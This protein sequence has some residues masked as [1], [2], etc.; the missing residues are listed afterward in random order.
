MRDN[1]IYHAANICSLK[2][3]SSI[4]D[5]CS[6]QTPK[7]INKVYGLNCQ[8]YKRKCKFYVSK[9]LLSSYY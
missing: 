6:F 5:N 2:N 9:S 8:H 4:D 7:A 1:N 3:S